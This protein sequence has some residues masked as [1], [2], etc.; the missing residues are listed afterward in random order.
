MNP[1]GT[2][3]EADARVAAARAAA[4]YGWPWDDGA[5][6]ARVRRAVDDSPDC[7]TVHCA[8][9]SGDWLDQELDDTG[10]ELM[11]DLRSGEFVGLKLPRSIMSKAE[12]DRLHARR[13]PSGL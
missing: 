6:V 1:D 9:P 4:H 3:T 5:A 12:L 13:H 10:R 11:I 2:L 7:W 8:M